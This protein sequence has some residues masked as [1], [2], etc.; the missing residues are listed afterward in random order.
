MTR[1]PIFLTDEE[2]LLLSLCAE[3]LAEKN[4]D[5]I[6]QGKLYGAAHEI[7]SQNLLGQDYAK[8]GTLS[9]HAGGKQ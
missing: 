1:R 9:Q 4:P 3:K 8:L 6:M 2:V 5:K 7:K